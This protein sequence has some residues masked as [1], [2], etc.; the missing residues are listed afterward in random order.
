MLRSCKFQNQTEWGV[1]LFLSNPNSIGHDSVPMCLPSERK[2]LVQRLEKVRLGQEMLFIAQL[3]NFFESGV[4]LRN[5]LSLI[6][7]I[8]AVAM[9]KSGRPV[10]RLLVLSGDRSMEGVELLFGFANEFRSLM[11]GGFA[12]ID[13]APA[14][15]KD[16]GITEENEPS[17]F[18]DFR[19]AV[20]VLSAARL[21][22]SEVPGLARAEWHFGFDTRAPSRKSLGHFDYDVVGSHSIRIT[23]DKTGFDVNF[24]DR[25][26]S[27]HCEMLSAPSPRVYM[28][29][30]DLTERDDPLSGGASARYLGMAAGLI[31]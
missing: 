16:A 13:N 28:I 25:F 30:L 29:S 18:R 8:N 19:R 12:Q 17:E 21:T 3:K 15:M 27:G 6:L 7:C 9:W 4:S 2:A 10:S 26:T 31:P 11:Q 20:R 24:R 14:W 23:S 5:I 22:P 1:I